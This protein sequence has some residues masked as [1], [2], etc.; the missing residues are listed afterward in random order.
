MTKCPAP[1]DAKALEELAIAIVP[2]EE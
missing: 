1:A 2:E